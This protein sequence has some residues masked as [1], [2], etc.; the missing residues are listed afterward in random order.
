MVARWTASFGKSYDYSGKTY[1]YIPIP[2]LLNDLIP[3]ISNTIGFTTNNCLINLYHDGNSSMGYHSDNIDILAPN[4]GVVIISIGS[5]RTLRF[6]NKLNKETIIDYTL[7]DGSLF[8]M[9][10]DIQKHWLHSIPKS[11]A[12]GPRISLTFRNIK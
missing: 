1:P 7:S 12:T 10:D 3:D 9:N 4:T 5:T 11:D 6:K 8:Y 2:D